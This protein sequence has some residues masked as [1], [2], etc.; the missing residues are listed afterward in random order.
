MFVGPD[1]AKSY[2]KICRGTNKLNGLDHY[3]VQNNLM[4]EVKLRVKRAVELD[5]LKCKDKKV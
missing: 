4:R 2:D 3:Q 1:E 5:K